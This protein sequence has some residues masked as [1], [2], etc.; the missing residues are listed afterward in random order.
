MI[1]S[2]LIEQNAQQLTASVTAGNPVWPPYLYIVTDCLTDAMLDKLHAYATT[3]PEDAWGKVERQL[4][5]NR[6]SINWDS[7]TVIEEA[8]IIFDTLTDTLSKRYLEPLHFHGVQLWKDQEGYNI[9]WHTDNTIIAVSLQIYLFDADGNLGT[10]FL[11]QNNQE[12]DIPF[13]NNTGY[14]AHITSD[15]DLYHKSTTTI[16]AGVNRYSLYAYWS[17]EPKRK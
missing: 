1:D 6:A 17:L 11:V 16:P 4:G 7:D 15:Q 3:A 2:A 14:L 9:K 13:K 12:L 8:H 5:Y 10:T